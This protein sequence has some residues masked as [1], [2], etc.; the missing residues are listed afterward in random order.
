MRSL[1]FLLV[2]LIFAL[3]SFYIDCAVKPYNQ[4]LQ[5]HWSI[6]DGLLQVVANTIIQDD[7][8]YIWVGSQFGLTRFDGVRF[9]TFTRKDHPALGAYIRKLFIDSNGYMWIGTSSGLLL[10]KDKKFSSV[11]A[12]I[13]ITDNK[14]D[15]Y[16]IAE[17]DD[18]SIIFNSHSGTYE[19]INNEINYS[20]FFSEAPAYGLHIQGSE[21][22][23]GNIGY[24]THID[25]SKTH[26]ISFPKDK[27]LL[28]VESIKEH[29]AKLWIATNAGLYT[30]DNGKLENYSQHQLLANAPITAML[31][32]SDKVLWA[33]TNGGI[34]RIRY[35]EI[36][37]F[38]PDT[39]A[40]AFKVL[41][42][43]FE[44]KEKNIWLGSYVHGIAKLSKAYAASFG[45]ESGLSEPIVWSIQ[46][47]HQSGLFVGTNNGLEY[48][49]NNQ[50]EHLV[51]GAD[52]PHPVVYSQLLTP[53]GL[54]LGTRA[55]AALYRNNKLTVPEEF[56]LLA[57]SH[58][59]GISRIAEGEY[60][61]ATDNGLFYIKDKKTVLFSKDENEISLSLSLVHK[62]ADNRILLGSSNGV[63]EF[64]DNRVIKLFPEYATTSKFD[65]TAIYE[66]DEGRFVFGTSSNGLISN[67]G[68]EWKHLSETQAGLPTPGGFYIAKDSDDYL[69]V[70]SFNGLYRFPYKQ[71][72]SY[73]PAK[74]GSLTVDHVLDDTGRKL[75]A[76]KS[77]CCTGGGTS[78]G[79][80][81]DNIITLPS[82]TGIIRIN[83]SNFSKNSVAPI[84]LVESV[85]IDDKWLDVESN[86]NLILDSSL[87]DLEIR[88]TT[89][90]FVDAKNSLLQYKLA[91][92]DDDWKY[93]Q[94]STRRLAT[95]TNLPH[96]D[97]QFIVKGTN[98]SGVWGEESI[99][100]NF[101]IEPHY[102]ET[103]LFYFVVISLLVAISFWMHRLRIISLEKQKN[104]LE[105]E[106]SKKTAI[107]MAVA[108]AGQQ[109]TAG[110]DFL[111]TMD[112]VYRN[113]KSFMSADSF[114]IGLCSEDRKFL[115]YDYSISQEK[116]YIPYRRAMS[117]KMSLP[118]WCV[119]NRKPVFINDINKEVEDYM[120]VMSAD[121]FNSN[122]RMLED[123]T[124]EEK[125]RSMIY[126]PIIF[127][128]VALGMMGI[129]SF[130]KNQY[131]KYH[132]DMLQSIANYTA[133]AIIN[134]KMY[135]Q[136][137]LSEKNEKYRIK[138]EKK[139]AE[140]ANQAKSQFLATMSHE[141]RTP[142][143][144]VIGMVELL[145]S[146]ELKDIQQHYVDVI[147]RSG[148]ILL[149][150][151]NDILDYSKIEA[152]KM[153]LES[154]EF[155][156]LELIGDCVEFFE[157]MANEKH[158]DFVVNVLPDTAA[159]YKGDPTRISQLLINLLGNAFKFTDS[160]CVVL[161]IESISNDGEEA[162]QLKFSVQDTGI[163]ISKDSQLT[164]FDSFNQSDNSMTRKYGGTGLGLAISKRLVE[165]MDGEIGVV[166]DKGHGANFWFTIS[167]PYI[168]NAPKPGGDIKVPEEVKQSGILV[169]GDDSLLFENMKQ[170]FSCLGINVIQQS[171]DND[172]KPEELLKLTESYHCSLISNSWMVE[173]GEVFVHNFIQLRNAD[174]RAIY[175]YGV[176]TKGAVN[177]SDMPASAIYNL[178]NPTNFSE[179]KRDINPVE[180][181]KDKQTAKKVGFK[182]LRVLVAEDN[183]INKIVIKSMLSKLSITPHLAENGTKALELFS[184]PDNHYDL[185]LMDCEMPEMDGFQATEAIRAY[186]MEHNISR[187]TIVA[188]TAHTTKE[189]EQRVYAAGMDL[190]LTKP[191]T[192]N[193]LI[194]AIKSFRVSNVG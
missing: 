93:L 140:S 161:K 24:I 75:G 176:L 67:Y 63:Y 48:F 105:N 82:R 168:E 172:I 178:D 58:V 8:G 69:W 28:R 122:E 151:I 188:L 50:F 1:S 164:L 191:L 33:A 83:T 86:N 59:R 6:E 153:V 89:F 72:K 13:N 157:V 132:I 111:D 35:G 116:R 143:N 187:T 181:N 29:N 180:V 23:I 174:S 114:S 51:D 113:I 71:L 139:L 64:K 162:V 112:T 175:L 190:Y 134:N 142:M 34:F 46:Q 156:L 47:S 42:S 70:S 173:Q 159:F 56:A 7:F 186:E 99:P 88:F 194:E 55:G 184:Q 32:D 102:Y 41:L 185:I 25:N 66:D 149:N 38:I 128:D 17:L 26:I 141:I 106:V 61:F 163:G 45:V 90:S 169:T 78:K 21:I 16:D 135:E 137:I 182:G 57:Y 177:F 120:M 147:S 36:Y 73:M 39:H 84:S 193:N 18:G 53:E 148:K 54:I 31:E 79:L 154:V 138:K 171:I 166:S 85:K 52:L 125:K 100:F 40:K 94:D 62:T 101:T 167:L 20:Q 27:P 104:K 117:D 95:Y 4:Y 110:F 115:E 144:G 65:I 165:I 30:L 131:Q 14:F 127:N 49:S 118:V 108:E 96:G 192:L 170:H 107:I 68:K 12:N 152:G 37:E 2:S 133:I 22:W 92:Y 103:K 91:G 129:Q 3:Q 74:S 158:I 60:F 130:S 97:Y 11:S 81:S 145:K 77:S 5:E 183:E 15:I 76:E 121:A 119:K 146:T 126:V 189:H 124:I 9:K 98:N 179:L 109:I 87:R 44:D 155:N 10:Y 150:I 80:F 136:K 43:I 123:G 19:V 160:G